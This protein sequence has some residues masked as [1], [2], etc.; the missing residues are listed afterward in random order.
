MIGVPSPGLGRALI[1]A[2]KE[3][4]VFDN[5][6]ADGTAVL[7]LDVFWFSGNLAGV[8]KKFLVRRLWSVKNSNPVPWNLLVP[9]LIC[10]LTVLPPAI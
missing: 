8:W 3:Q 2:E 5:R 9:D 4:F 7:L 6:F 10:T 1:V